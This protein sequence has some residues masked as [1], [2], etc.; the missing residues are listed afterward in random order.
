M[1]SG[2]RNYD[3]VTKAASKKGSSALGAK[4]GRGTPV[5]QQIREKN[6]EIFKNDVPKR[7]IGRK[8]WI[9]YLQ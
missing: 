3:F 7:K 9:F 2:D 5:C 1:S 6:V 8:M 4:M